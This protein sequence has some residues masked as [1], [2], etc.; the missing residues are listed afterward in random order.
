M[1]NEV[2]GASVPEV[3]MARM[4]KAQEKGPEHA[5]REGIAIAQEVVGRIKDLV[6]GIQISPPL[7]KY[8]LALEVLEALK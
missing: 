7:G 5:W 8:E 1:H 4:R 2:P 3:I 6:A